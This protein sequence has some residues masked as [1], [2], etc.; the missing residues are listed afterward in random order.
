MTKTSFLLSSIIRADI[1]SR[2]K[3]EHLQ[4]LQVINL[5]LRSGGHCW[6]IHKEQ[7]PHLRTMSIICLLAFVIEKAK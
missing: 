6:V 7:D 3:E 2:L 4:S 5:P 1:V